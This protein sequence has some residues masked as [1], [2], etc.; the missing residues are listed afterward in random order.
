MSNPRTINPAELVNDIRSGMTDVQLMEKHK[1]SL[2]SLASLL[3]QLVEFK[4]LRPREVFGRLPEYADDVVLE[5]VE[6]T[7]ESMRKLPRQY[8]D[9]S[10]GVLDA[11]DP[12]ARGWLCDVTEE[13][14]GIKG[15]ACRV[16]ENRTLLVTPYQ[17]TEC[18]PFLV[19]AEC[20][21]CRSRV[22]EEDSAGFKI[23]AISEESLTELRKLVA[24]A[25]T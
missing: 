8:V 25:S 7:L 21:W 13:G 15:I 12:E 24:A 17:R 14:L 20:R 11:K 6:A 4:A 3:K 23:T 16:G 5:N 9:V 22:G 18:E 1:V 19:R 2:R 10:V